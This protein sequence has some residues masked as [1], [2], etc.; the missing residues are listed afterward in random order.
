MNDFPDVSHVM[1]RPPF[2]KLYAI[3]LTFYAFDKQAYVRAY[4]DRLSPI[5]G[6][7]KKN[8]LLVLFGVVSC[9]SGPGIGFYDVFYNMHMHCLIVAFF[10]IGEI[11]YIFTIISVL[12]NNRS[13]F[14]EAASSKIDR[15]ILCRAILFVEGVI[16]LGSKYIHYDLHAYGAFIEWT[17]F[18]MTFYV[19]TL[20]SEVMPYELKVVRKDER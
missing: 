14:P 20:L 10:V 9:I 4:H 1:G 17:V 5:I 19:F 13:Q 8:S 16:S 6:E 15:L 3:M 12:K 11:G 7:S 2:N 18:I